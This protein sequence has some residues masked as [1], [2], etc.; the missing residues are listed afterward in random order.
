[1]PDI[2]PAEA[3]VGDAIGYVRGRTAATGEEYKTHLFG[4]SKHTIT[5]LRIEPI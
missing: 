5:T 4:I 3:E 1:M 2:L